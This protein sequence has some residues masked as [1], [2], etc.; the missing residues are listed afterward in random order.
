MSSVISEQLL[1]KKTSEVV[2]NLPHSLRCPAFIALIERGFTTPKAQ[3][4]ILSFSAY[5]FWFAC[6]LLKP[7]IIT[8]SVLCKNECRRQIWKWIVWAMFFIITEKGKSASCC[9]AFITSSCKYVRHHLLFDVILFCRRER[10]EASST[11]T[12]YHI[13]TA[14]WKYLDVTFVPVH[15]HVSSLGKRSLSLKK[16]FCICSLPVLD[17]RAR[18]SRRSSS[19]RGFNAA[20]EPAAWKADGSPVFIA[21]RNHKFLATSGKDSKNRDQQFRFLHN[22]SINLLVF[23]VFDWGYKL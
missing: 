17:F 3:I 2:N 11:K 16:I 8:V 22:G 18:K 13:H 14:N 23:W 5:F 20:V 4:E 6:K 21:T 9:K 12:W 7:Y 15:G 1:G 10:V 19:F